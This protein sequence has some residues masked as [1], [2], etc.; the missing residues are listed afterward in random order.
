[1]AITFKRN[2]NGNLIEE[3]VGVRQTGDRHLFLAECTE[4]GKQYQFQR[5]VNTAKRRC[6]CEKRKNELLINGSY[7]TLEKWC[8][9][10]PTANLQSAKVRLSD[11]KRG[12][13]DATDLEIL[14]GY[15]KYT[16]G[17]LNIKTS[18][19]DKDWVN[20]LVNEIN[21]RLH[22]MP[23][24]DAIT[25]AVMKVKETT[26]FKLDKL[27]T[28]YTDDGLAFTYGGQSL[29]DLEANFSSRQE[30]HNFLRQELEVTDDTITSFYKLGG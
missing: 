11:R 6:A 22:R 13:R 21:K 16:D 12:K 20:Y 19:E 27:H 2:E 24:I 10:F 25:A 30:L 4:C 18:D 29:E 1:M 8:E 9:Q 3:D 23:L 17:K 14:W 5:N 28:P 7:K 15:G 26:D